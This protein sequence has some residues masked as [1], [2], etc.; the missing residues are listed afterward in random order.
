MQLAVSG[1]TV[2]DILCSTPPRYPLK[3]TTI[4]DSILA[5]KRAGQKRKENDVPFHAARDARTETTVHN[6]FNIIIIIIK[7]SP[8]VTQ[9]AAN[10]HTH[11]W[12]VVVLPPPPS[13]CPNKM[14]VYPCR[15][16]LTGSCF[17]MLREKLFHSSVSR[18]RCITQI[19]ANRSP[20][21]SCG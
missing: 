2:L 13:F 6:Q 21:L 15:C 11:R 9:S 20:Q 7:N 8:D 19:S 3:P 14:G 12:G 4:P 5:D 17:G 16:E 10:A 18:L 1:R